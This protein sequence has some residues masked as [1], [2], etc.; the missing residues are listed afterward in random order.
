M[1]KV[2]VLCTGNSCRSQ[3]A[4]GF[5]RNFD[6]NVQSAGVESHGLNPYAVKVMREVDVDISNH[7]SK[8]INTLNLSS[9]DILI[10]VCDHAKETCPNIIGIKT[11]IHKSFR[12]PAVS[13]GSDDEKLLIYREVRDQ[14]NMFC[15]QFINQYYHYK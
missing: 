14:I 7:N 11:N 8:K 1:K 12:D 10:T 2:L 13:V 5:L 3:M 15:R 9:F 6:I 4:E